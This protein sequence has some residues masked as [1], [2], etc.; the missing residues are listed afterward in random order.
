MIPKSFALTQSAIPN[1]KK[2][3]AKLMTTVVIVKNKFGS[4][5][6]HLLYLNLNSGR[7]LSNNQN[8]VRPP[9]NIKLRCEDGMVSK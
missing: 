1:N 8:N 7:P 6:C 4:A 5:C 3:N 9:T 2:A